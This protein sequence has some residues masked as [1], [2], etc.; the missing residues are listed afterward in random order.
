VTGSI[1]SAG[2][3]SSGCVF[4]FSSRRFLSRGQA[5]VDGKSEEQSLGGTKRDA[6]SERWR[7]KKFENKFYEGIGIV[8][9]VLNDISDLAESRHTASILFGIDKKTES[10]EMV[11]E[12]YFSSRNDVRLQIKLLIKSDN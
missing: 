9:P 1:R 7:R 11:L 5:D 8:Y 12:K 2:T 4:P 10:E 6:R 3:T